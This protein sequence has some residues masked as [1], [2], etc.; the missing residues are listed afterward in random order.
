[1]DNE[2]IDV[3]AHHHLIPA[4]TG[5]RAFSLVPSTMGEAMQMA[6]MIA[7]SD[8]APKDYVGKAGNILI[9]IQM[10][11]DVGLKPMQALQ[12][13]AVING[14]PS[15]WGDAAI[16][17]VQNASVLERFHETFEGGEMLLADGKANLEFT[18]VCV[19]KRKGFPDEVRRTFSIADAIKAGLWSKSGPWQTYPKRMLQM[20]ARAFALRDGAADVLMGLSIVEEALDFPQ[21]T[22]TLM[23]AGEGATATMVAPGMVEFNKL[24]E[25][26]RDNIEKAFETLSL[27]PGM[28][29][30]K[31]NEYLLAT[32]AQAGQPDLTLEDKA[33][34]LIEWCRDE[35][36]KRKNGLPR[37]AK[38]D[39]NGKGSVVNQGAA[40]P[41]VQGTDA[42]DQPRTGAAETTAASPAQTQVTPAKATIDRLG[43]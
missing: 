30:A 32:P 38:G 15:I 33:T 29:L 11:L 36:A 40:G 35:Y 39:P 20:R 12:N 10:G 21:G 16:A 17:L 7:Q 34:R 8:F 31:L 41:V 13:I 28:R 42:T 27:A 6:T 2:V 1:M 25:A 18:A 43:F 14:R 26:Q 37:A 9:A 23:P 3:G 4:T 19:L 24:P 22:Q 5:G